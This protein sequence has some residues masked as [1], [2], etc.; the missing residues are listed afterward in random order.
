MSPTQ[1]GAL[2]ANPQFNVQFS[3]CPFASGKC[4]VNS[5]QGTSKNA[6]TPTAAAVNNTYYYSSVTVNNQSCNNGA[7]TFGLHIKPGTGLKK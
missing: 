5:P 2:G 3:S 7:S 1:L 4:P 6:G